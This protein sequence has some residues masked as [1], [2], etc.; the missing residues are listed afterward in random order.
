MFIS[1][2]YVSR[3]TIKRVA[4]KAEVD[5]TIARWTKRNARLRIRGA[6]LITSGHVAQILEGPEESV[7]HLME[8]MRRDPRHEN[9]TVIERK[10]IDGYRFPDWC[11][12]YWGTASYMDRKIAAV[13]AKHEALSEAGETA[14]LFDL[15]RLLARESHHG[16]GPIGQPPGS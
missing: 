11:F 1:L 13:M 9:V 10:P 5:A 15:M 12:A 2:I 7:D 16:H 3:R 4:P 6:L 8:R 14:E